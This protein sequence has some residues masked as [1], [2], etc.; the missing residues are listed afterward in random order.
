[1][2]KIKYIGTADNF[3]ELAYTGKQSIWKDGQSEFRSDAEA[4]QLAASGMFE[5]E[6]VPLMG[7]PN[8]VTGVVI[9]NIYV[10]TQAQYD[11]L[12]AASQVDASTN[13]K[14]VS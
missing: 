5:F 2:P 3:S 11:A 14:I 8:P 12:V 13:Y 6:A 7:R 9:K 1:M 4:A 10:C